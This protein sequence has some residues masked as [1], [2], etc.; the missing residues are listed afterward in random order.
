MKACLGVGGGD[1]HVQYQR[2]RQWGSLHRAAAVGAADL[3]NLTAPDGGWSMA[4][5]M[6]ARL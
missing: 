6:M 3:W 2:Q 4:L 1:E 5:L